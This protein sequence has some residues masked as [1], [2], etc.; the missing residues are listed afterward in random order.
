MS[1]TFMP[2]VTPHLVVAGADAAIAFY[3]KAFG[4]QEVMRLP[5][6]DGRRLIHASLRLNG[7]MV[8]LVDDFPEH[9]GGVAAAPDPARPSPV[10]VHLEVPDVDA[11]IA[12]AAEAGALVTMPAADMFWGQRYGQLRDP[13]GH[14]WSVGGPLKG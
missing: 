13:F 2:P 7:A 11:A 14:S 6:E 5:A 8:M 4:A 10:T 9:H 3:A 12:R 1:D